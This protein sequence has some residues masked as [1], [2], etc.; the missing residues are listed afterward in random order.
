MALIRTKDY[1]TVSAGVEDGRTALVGVEVDD[2]V[3]SGRRNL[4]NGGTVTG[5]TL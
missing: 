1:Q 3:N 2:W 4:V 5:R